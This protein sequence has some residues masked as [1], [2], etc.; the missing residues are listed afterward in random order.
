VA[1][2]PEAAAEQQKQHKNW[3]TKQQRFIFGPHGKPAAAGAA[4]AAGAAEDWQMSNAS[5]EAAMT[6]AGGGAEDGP[7]EA[8]EAKA[9]RAGPP[10]KPAN[11]PTMTKRSG[12]NTR[13][14]PF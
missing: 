5:A 3:V 13:F 6:A 14:T 10:A 7:G 1:E 8:A 9:H 4:G 11:W 12:T 2:D